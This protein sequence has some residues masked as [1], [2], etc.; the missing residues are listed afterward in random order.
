MSFLYPSRKGQESRCSRR[1]FLRGDSDEVEW[2]GETVDGRDLLQL[3]VSF[4]QV[5]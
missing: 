5:K 4:L 2:R 3:N 1:L